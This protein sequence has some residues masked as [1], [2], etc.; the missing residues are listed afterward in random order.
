VSND[1]EEFVIDYEDTADDNEEN[2]GVGGWND[3]LCTLTPLSGSNDS[4][5]ASTVKA[6]SA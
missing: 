2:G 6:E 1:P 3:L 5:S 4:L